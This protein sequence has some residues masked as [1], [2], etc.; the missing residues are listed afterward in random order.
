MLLEH[1]VSLSLTLFHLAA[2]ETS[3]V[4]SSRYPLTDCLARSDV[5]TVNGQ[6]TKP[7]KKLAER[8]RLWHKILV[9]SVDSS[10]TNPSEAGALANQR[11]NSKSLF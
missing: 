1:A 10:V 4:A 6:N 2:T 7:P 9:S 8:S 5:T 11:S 3:S